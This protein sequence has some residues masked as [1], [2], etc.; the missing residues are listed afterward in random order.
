MVHTAAWIHV[1]RDCRVNNFL[2]YTRDIKHSHAKTHVRPGPN[3]PFSRAGSLRSTVSCF[4]GPL[5]VAFLIADPVNVISLGI[6]FPAENVSDLHSSPAARRTLETD[7][8]WRTITQVGTFSKGIGVWCKAKFQLRNNE[9][10]P[11][12]KYAEGNGEAH[13]SR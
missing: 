5:S 6:L 12:L 1:K 7:V 4:V 8:R 3:H 13:Y 9:R 11:V 10:R 2:A